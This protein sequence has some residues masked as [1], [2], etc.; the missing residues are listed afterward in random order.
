MGSQ[1]LLDLLV[2]VWGISVRMPFQIVQRSL[3]GLVQMHVVGLSF[4]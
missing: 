4:V 2:G 3:G 1:C